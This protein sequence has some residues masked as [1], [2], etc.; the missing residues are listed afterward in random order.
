MKTPIL[1]DDANDLHRL[2]M[3]AIADWNPDLHALLADHRPQGRL[4]R[5]EDGGLDVE[6]RGKTLYGRGGE[7]CSAERVKAS[8][9]I[10]D[11]IAYE[12]PQ[13]KDLDTQAGAYVR[14]IQARM[15]TAGISVPGQLRGRHTSFLIV[16]GIGLGF[17][18]KDLVD[19]TRCTHLIIV[20]PTLEYLYQST[21]TCD[22]AGLVV[23]LRTRNARIQVIVSG[24]A[25]AVATGIIDAVRL[26]CPVGFDGLTFHR[27]YEHPVFTRA[28][29][30]I[31]REGTLMV[32]GLG[33][34]DDELFMI[35]HS[36]RNLNPGPTRILRA[37]EDTIETPVFIVGGGPSKDEQYDFLRA[38]QGKAVIMSC[39]SALDSLLA[40]GI[41][42]DFHFMLE[43]FTRWYTFLKQ[44]AEDY[45]LSGIT[46]VAS[47]TVEPLTTTLFERTIYFFRNA[48]SP[49]PI[50]GEAVDGGLLHAG[51]QVANT[52]L[53]MAQ[54]LGFKNVYFF[55]VD[56]GSRD[57]ALHH[58]KHS[59]PMREGF[60]G[61]GETL[62]QSIPGNFGGV[63]HS[64]TNL[65]FVRAVL[66]VAIA[67][68]SE[69][70]SYYNCSDGGLIQGAVPTPIDSLSLDAYPA[71]KEARVETIM[72]GMPSFQEGTFDGAW[73]AYGIER[74]IADFQV[75][76]ARCLDD[77]AALHDKTYLDA[78][79][80]LFN[81]SGPDAGVAM[82]FRGTLSWAVIAGEYYLNRLSDGTRMAELE[83]ILRQELLALLSHLR[84]QALDAFEVMA[85]KTPE[86]IAFNA[87]I[88]TDIVDR[89]VAAALL[90]PHRHATPEPPAAPLDEATRGDEPV[91]DA[92]R[93]APC[94]CGSGRRFKQCHGK[95][96]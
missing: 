83:E 43:R 31:L 18:L 52:A 13:A 34:L 32:A 36:I 90:Y 67:T 61:A 17:H 63:V 47:T 89:G 23:G 14:R 48:L 71:D 87:S 76:F 94:P 10:P 28:R 3:E 58:S 21:F 9:N 92:P 16:F 96:N 6:L 19:E 33:F 73:E 44:T 81:V 49:Y 29:D 30:R 11:R 91:Y 54:N 75:R 79:M 15:A 1:D 37:R 12:P 27:H 82:L 50:F 59:W 26:N 69:G 35:R 80:A 93:N 65:I 72:A 86:A 41:R 85:A 56:L 77:H 64:Q 53:A 25:E 55:G 84:D 42:P 78:V 8:W 51:P 70:R 95:L 74:R 88:E 66:E 5:A 46:L 2:N 7:E 22:W 60:K 39:G 62:D 40:E 68:F 4:I 38:H 20:E 57:P 24:D 45:D